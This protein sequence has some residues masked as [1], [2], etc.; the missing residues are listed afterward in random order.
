MRVVLT[1]DAR[2]ALGSILTHTAAHRPA[3]VA[4]LPRV[5]AWPESAPTVAERPG[6]HLVPILRPPNLPSRG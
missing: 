1:A 4:S 2:R 5:G 3:G 6:L